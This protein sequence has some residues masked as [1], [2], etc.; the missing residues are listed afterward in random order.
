MQRHNKTRLDARRH[1]SSASILPVLAV[2]AAVITLPATVAAT[3]KN[4]PTRPA[5]ITPT[6]PITGAPVVIA[7]TFPD[8]ATAPGMSAPWLATPT[9]PEL[10]ATPEETRFSVVPAGVDVVGDAI[11][12]ANRAVERL[13]DVSDSDRTFENTVAALDDIAAQLEFETSMLQFM[14]YVSTD[15]SERAA[16]NDAIERIQNWM[17]DLGKNEQVFGAIRAYAD[18]NPRLQG[19]KKRLLEHI[20]RDYR[21]AGMALSSVVRK[22][23]TAIEK[24]VAALS[25]QFEKN[26]LEDDTAVLVERSELAG[27]P[28]EYIAGLDRAGSMY[29]IT[30]DYPTFLPLMDYCENEETREKVWI[31]YKRRGGRKNVSVIE[32]IV[33]LRAQAADL[34]GYESPA[35]Y[36]VE[37]RMAKTPENVQQ[38]YAKLQPLVRR[39]ALLDYEELTQA[40]RDHTGNPDAKLRPW[41]S[42]FYINRLKREKYAVDSEKVREYFP[43]HRVIDG[44]FSITQSLYGLEYREITDR[45]GSGDWPLWHED[46][47]LF[48]VWDRND[49]TL[50]GHFYI[51]L[52]PRPDKY[53]HAAQWGLRQ[54]KLWT[55]GTYEKPLAALVCNFT[56]PTGDKPSLMSHDE[57]ETF[58]HEF[59]HCLHTILS[60]AEYYQFAGTAV[61]RDFVEAPS[62]MFENWVWDVDVL[63]TF[64]GHY[65]TGEKL[66]EEMLAGMIAAKNL[67]SGMLAERQFFYGLFDFTL[68]SNPEGDIDS[69]Q[70]AHAL[71]DPS[72]KD[73]ELYEPV[74]GTWFHASFGH[75]TGYQ[76]GYYGYQWSLV[77]AADM[78]ERF[79]ELGMLNPEAGMYYRNKIL[80]RGG[81][82]DGLD[83]VRDYL[84]REPNMD[85]FLRHLGL[86]TD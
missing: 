21:R 76:A 86:Q 77:Y 18:T 83:M 22:E 62:Q 8:I 38:F 55:N 46:V 24:Q 54:H 44:L 16:G 47:R 27:M 53:G 56:K 69:I 39:K 9:V 78:F 72:G 43:L 52:H 67:A 30:M 19:E 31:A 61:E 10:L 41:D 66:P 4:A 45:A 5:A 23:L 1:V 3:S 12:R 75:L 70:L 63:N 25:I 35:E 6:G 80:S 65:K 57:V 60:E 49:R 34:L 32:K 20:L 85:A 37:V 64:A 36:E 40:K 73:V 15:A 74:P 42:S 82:V 50:L 28:K 84:G 14:A 71:W 79:E 58:F 33:S 2:S 17:I 29:I 59:G 13:T 26:I 11:S 68:H 51:D 81:T 48:E 7:M